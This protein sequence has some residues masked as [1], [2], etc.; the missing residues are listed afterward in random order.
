MP[1]PDASKKSP[2]VYTNLQNIDLE[3]ITFA[4]IEATGNP[5]AIEELNEDELRRLVLCNLAR[6]V[7]KGEWTGLLESGGGA[8]DLAD[9]SDVLL[10]ATNFVDGL[11]IQPDSDAAA[12]TTGTLS[13]ATGNLGIG[14]EVL[15]ALTSGTYNVI[16]GYQAAGGITDGLYNI[17]IG[18]RAMYTNTGSTNIAIGPETCKGGDGSNN[19][20]IGNAALSGEL[21]GS[22]NVAVGQSALQN[23]TSGV[24]NVTVGRNAGM[25]C[26]TGDRNVA[27]GHRALRN[28]S[29]GSDSDDNLGI[30]AGALY[31]DGPSGTTNGGVTGTKNA[32]VGNFCLPLLVAGNNN[33]AFGYGAA[34]NITSADGCVV[35]GVDVDT[36]SATDDRQLLIAGNDGSTQTS[37]IVGDNAGACYQGDNETAWSTT[38]DRRLKREIA[39]AT[40]G[41]EAINEIKLRNFRYRKDNQYGLD[42][43]PSRVG[44]I[45]QELEEVF[46]EAVKENAH[47]HKTVSTDSINWALLKAVQE[48]SAKVEALESS[49]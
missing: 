38:S 35:I 36:A 49:Q 41:L 46:P 20:G 5:I 13:D 44:V 12:P 30:G 18:H 45:A 39:D 37:W 48:L 17:A 3:N 32:G 43:E 27:I 2:R 26:V 4:N 34:G 8:E 28:W 19:I 25:N 21:T 10:Y 24:Q 6:L 33:L 9:L 31:E 23:T 1:L 22:Y 7:V 29:N 15:K 42:P 14:V 16:L 47:G 11:L 40:K